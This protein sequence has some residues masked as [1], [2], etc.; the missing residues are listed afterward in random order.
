VLDLLEEN[1]SMSPSAALALN[2]RILEKDAAPAANLTV[3]CANCDPDN[4]RGVPR[5]ACRKCGGSGRSRVGLSDIVS[6]LRASRLELLVGGKSRER[7]F[8]D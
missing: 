1:T 7:D 3:E 8:D 6:E 5:E 4:P 2:C